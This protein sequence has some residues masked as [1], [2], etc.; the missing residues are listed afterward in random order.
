MK[1]V[2]KTALVVGLCLAL[3]PLRASAAPPP[4]KGKLVYSDDFSDPQKSGLEDNIE[5]TD[6]S[7]GFHAPGFYHLKD[8]KPNDTRWELFPN[9]A[10]GTFTLE[11]DVFDNSDD[12]TGDVAQGVVV[13]AQDDDHLYAVLVDPRKGQYAIRKLDGKDTWSDL[14]G[15]KASPLVKKQAEVNHLRVDG[16]GDTFTVYLN[17]EMLDSFKDAAYAKGQLGLITSNVDAAQPHMHFDNVNV[18][19]TEAGTAEPAGSAATGTL[20][21]TGTASRGSPLL[22]VGVAL[23]LLSLGVW[24]RPRRHSGPV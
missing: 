10:Y 20:P 19:T 14:V 11:L 21:N 7:R 4:P 23:V 8:V 6:Y 13:R 1:T 18:Y 2:V 17:G 16:E 15:W 5:A 12:F 24:V 3:W 9:Q 22:L